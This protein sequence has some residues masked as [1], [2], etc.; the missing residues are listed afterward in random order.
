[1][2]VA[3][4]WELWGAFLVSAP[5]G[6]GVLFRQSPV[7]AELGLPCCSSWSST[8][9]GVVAGT[10][11]LPGLRG[12]AGSARAGQKLICHPDVRTV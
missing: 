8:G 1:M 3:T 6:G 10:G 7:Q 12:R 9:V 5:C 4:V 11:M 2:A